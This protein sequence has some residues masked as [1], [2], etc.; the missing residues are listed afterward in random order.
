MIKNV[1][2]DIGNVLL[3]FKPVEFLNKLY[4]K[5]TA[6]VLYKTIFRSPEWVCLDRGTITQEDATSNF[7]ER[8]PELKD[9]I[10][11]VMEHWNEIHTPI[12]D[13]VKLMRN[14]KS[15][16]YGIYLLSNYHKKAF[17]YISNKYDFI[18]N[19][20]GKIISSHYKLLKPEEKIYKALFD[21]YN[22]NP[23]ECIFIDDTP[24]NIEVANKLGIHGLCFKGSTEPVYDL[25]KSIG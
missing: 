13:T 17:D 22:L 9:K 1:I 8:K 23:D 14:L 5:E 25:I 11:F 4:D 3:Y 21:V 2:F 6:D 15:K 24:V 7:I 19:V 10:E 16:G 20:N 18:R 12:P